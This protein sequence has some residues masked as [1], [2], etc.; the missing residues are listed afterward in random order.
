MFTEWGFAC[1][2]KKYLLTFHISMVT[3]NRPQAVLNTRHIYCSVSLHHSLESIRSPWR[4]QQYVPP[5]YRN[6]K[7]LYSEETQT[8]ANMLMLI[9]CALLAIPLITISCQECP[10]FLL[11]YDPHNLQSQTLHVHPH[12]WSLFYLTTVSYRFMLARL[13]Y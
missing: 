13:S 8:K 6:I 11:R 7:P 4:W 2:R 9:L 1:C 12:V 5:K 3:V 10:V